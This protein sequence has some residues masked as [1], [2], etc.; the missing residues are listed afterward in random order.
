MKKL[1]IP[2]L[3]LLFLTG[4]W[5][6]QDTN[7]RIIVSGASI[8]LGE[9]G[10][11][12]VTAE[13]VSFTKNESSAQGRLISGSGS[14][15]SDAFNDILKK[16]GKEL[17]WR[18][19][20]VLVLGADYARNGTRELLDYI[21]NDHE[22]RLTL[23]LAVSGMEKGSDVFD[24]ETGDEKV[25]SQA[26]NSLLFEGDKLGFCKRVL[27]YDTIN[28]YAQGLR[29]FVL[30]LIIKGEDD[31]MEASGCAAFSG[32]K[33]IGTINSFESQYI[34]L[35]QGSL[36][37]MEFQV[38]EK[39]IKSSV[40]LANPSV[41]TVLRTDENTVIADIN[42]KCEYEVIMSIE[43]RPMEKTE[44][45]EIIRKVVAEQ[46]TNGINKTNEHFAL[47][48]CDIFGWGEQMY[49]KHPEEYE[50]IVSNG[51]LTIPVTI[52]FKSKINS[53]IEGVAGSTI[54]QEGG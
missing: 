3:F 21:L 13:I 1:I 30:P 2:M 8:D 22:M 10:E 14:S 49:R 48:G 18:H 19:A 9:N 20:T 31:V 46:L 24:L 34:H 40:N 41:K 47:L 53:R 15:I 37:S 52:D 33:M 38:D 27:A 5:N 26:I 17:Y 4:C 42:M 23:D 7:R 6:Y 35:L 54:N 50:K 29:D 45:M 11:T 25:V 12:L 51:R 16:S 44:Y 39:D 28:V 43:N 36:H 32:D